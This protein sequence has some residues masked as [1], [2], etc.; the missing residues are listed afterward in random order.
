MCLGDSPSCALLLLLTRRRSP[1]PVRAWSDVVAVT[2]SP[3]P[4]RLFVLRH[5]CLHLQQIQNCQSFRILS[6]CHP[7]PSSLAQNIYMHR[8]QAPVTYI[9]YSRN[10]LT[11]IT[12]SLFN[13]LAAAFALHFVSF[14]FVHLHHPRYERLTGRSPCL[15][16]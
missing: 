15:W 3:F 6:P 10:R 8:I 16:D 12:S 5:R 11:F 2:W 1:I 14:S 4:L 9:Q 7:T 13:L